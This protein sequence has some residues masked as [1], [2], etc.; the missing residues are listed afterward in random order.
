MLREPGAPAPALFTTR[1]ALSYLRGPLTREQIA[2]LMAGRYSPDAA[3]SAAPASAPAAATPPPTVHEDT[4]PVA[5][6]APAGVV[7]RWLDPAAPWITQVAGVVPTSTRMA[8]G[9]V[10]RVALLYDDRK[11][12]M[13]HTE[14]W[15]AV[16]VPLPA[17]FD[18][19]QAISVDH[20]DRDLR[21]EAPA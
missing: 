7:V 2:T 11:L 6:S 12:D 1:W 15:E 19:A 10:A 20:D 13:R 18:P 5:P 16:Y 21:T 14:E 9:L 17:T 3:P 8:P 4:A